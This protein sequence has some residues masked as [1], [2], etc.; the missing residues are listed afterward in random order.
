MA[1][2]KE[3]FSPFL[4][5]CFVTGAVCCNIVG[6]GCTL[7]YPGILLPQLKYPGSAVTITEAAESWLAAVTGILLLVGSFVAPPIMSRFGRKIVHLALT[8]PSLVGWVITILAVNFEMLLIGRILQG[9]SFGMMVPVRSVL[10]GEY[11]SPKNRGAFLTLVALAQ[12]FGIF[13]VH[14]LGS[15]ID[16][17]Q[18]A[19][20]CVF[21][22]F[23]SL[24]MA[25]YA[26]ESPSWLA[27]KRQ[28]D[29]CRK[30]FKWLRGYD[31]D[32]ELEEMIHAR[33]L[34]EKAANRENERKENLFK[35]AI[36]TIQKKEFY[37]PNLLMI[38]AFCMIQFVGGT[39]M[40]AYSTV[41]IRLIVGPDANAHFWMIALD[42]QRLVSNAIAVFV[43]NKVNRRTMMFSSGSLC[44]LS[45]MA[46]AGYV[47]AR[48]K[49]ILPYDAQWIPLL[50]INVQFFTV[51]VGMIPLPTIIAGEVF[52]LEYKAI[53]STISTWS[54]SVFMFL[55]LMTFPSL[56]NNIG[57]EG[58]YFVYSGLITLNLV[59]IWFLMPE[60]KGRTL[61]QIED[62]FRGRKLGGTDEKPTELDPVTLYRRRKS[63]R[64]CS[65]PLLH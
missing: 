51:A 41:I 30:V 48:N 36:S 23:F 5:Q 49:G 34:I 56:T 52:P 37:K 45:H 43:I 26:P 57:I 39:T 14:L 11:T 62:E 64:R 15:L 58:T 18:T 33:I 27:S 28:Y 16:W 17:Q 40:A 24:L 10:I 63:E 22:P 55:A 20:V 31:E 21:F 9:L 54:L 3:T 8:A 13:F 60:T 7:G 65:S 47:Y 2:R 4:R 29:K 19:L 46:I 50:L 32:D 1:G 25:I 61:Q 6:H 44:V 35:Q 53:S 12:A 38:S 59:V 42:T